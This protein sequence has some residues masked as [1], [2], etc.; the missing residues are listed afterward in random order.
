VSAPGRRASL[1]AKRPPLPSRAPGKVKTAASQPG[2]PA[3]WQKA[4]PITLAA[5]MSIDDAIAVIAAACRDHWQ[6]NMA[7][8]LAGAHPEG[9]HQVR[10]GLRRFRVLLSLAGDRIPDDQLT[11]L[12]AETKTLSDALG[13]ARDLEVFL[14]ELLAPLAAKA[15]DESEVA[16]LLRVVRENRDQAHTV[17]AAALSAPRYRRFMTRLNTWIDGR[18][19]AAGG[20]K[21]APSARTFA[22]TELN[23]RLAR[24]AERSKAVKT[25]STAKLHRLRIAIK[26]LRY[27]MEFFQSLLPD[28][29]SAR[30]N[31]DLKAMQDAL[32]YVNDRDVAKRMVAMLSDRAH[33]AATRAAVVQGGRRLTRSFDDGA[34][35]TLPRAAR[36]AARL[37]AEKP[38]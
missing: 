34:Q 26:K 14:T 19:W 8:A 25:M 11:W 24:L 35:A 21:R 32:G 37:R 36:A 31:R 33:D 9:I 17:A 10:V 16:A 18:G 38:L 23:R 1:K 2:A 27:G 3:A 20:S 15:A 22:R 29:R 13:P 30:I 12:K 6:A 4:K 28:K 7:A 5:S